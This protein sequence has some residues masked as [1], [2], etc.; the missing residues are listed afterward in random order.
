MNS[1]PMSHIGDTL[2][3]GGGF[4]EASEEA[5]RLTKLKELVS[6]NICTEPL[7]APLVQAMLRLSN[8]VSLLLL[9]LLLSPILM[10]RETSHH[11]Q[12]AGWYL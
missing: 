5:D 8:I 6:I 4:E 9:S 3:V 12:K 1:G 7:I 2:G 10:A 11:L